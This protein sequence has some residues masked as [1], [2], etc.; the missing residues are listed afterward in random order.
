MTRNRM[1]LN[2]MYIGVAAL[3]AV[4]FPALAEID[5]SG[6]WTAKNHEDAMERGAGR[7]QT[8]GQA[9]LSTTRAAPRL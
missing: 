1:C 4:G 2:K 8:T 9:F 7:I 5:L 6:S 3:L